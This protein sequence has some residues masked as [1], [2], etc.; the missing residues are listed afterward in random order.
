MTKITRKTMGV[1]LVAI[2]AVIIFLV[3]W[4]PM[5][6]AIST[7]FK[8][9]GEVYKVPPVWI[10]QHPTLEMYRR[11]WVGRSAGGVTEEGSPWGRYITNSLIVT[12]TT[13]IFAMILATF[14]G[15]SL[16]RFKF[17]GR[18]L[19]FILFIASQMFP[20]PMVMVPIYG[21]MVKLGLYN[22]L[23]G[24]IVIYTAS[25][26]P[27]TTLI[28]VGSL[29]NI[30]HELEESAM[31]DGCSRM[32]VFFRIVLPLSKIAVITT[33]IFAFLMS[34]GEYAFAVVLITGSKRFTVPLG[35]GR[36]ITAFDI[37][38]NE[39]SATILTIAIP[40]IFIFFAAQKHFVKGIIAGSLK[41]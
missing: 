28:S 20:G 40:L 14:A 26:L 37:Y 36:Y 38:W 3:I 19:I 35:L 2:V 30:P 24:L 41:G 6:W 16:A 34:F 29:R 21:I 39:I 17:P 13:V 5:L 27:F 23:A 33:G 11:V 22:T 4:F 31:I 1:V 15:Y 32:G 25:V 7:S 18:T 9:K 10:P 8:P 12:G